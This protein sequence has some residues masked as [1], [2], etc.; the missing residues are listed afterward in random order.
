[1]LQRARSL[2]RELQRRIRE[3]KKSTEEK[4]KEISRQKKFLRQFA[5]NLDE[6]LVDNE[7]SYRR[8]Q[9][10][11]I[12]GENRATVDAVEE[13]KVLHNLRVC[14][15]RY[16]ACNAPAPYCHQWPAP[17][18]NIFLHYLINGTIFE[19]EKSN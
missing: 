15:L 12:M 8:L 10:G 11:G 13:Q 6:R 3:I 14:R 19:K 2:K 18:Y 5:H 9:F 1:M 7:Q 4:K 16:P 17:L